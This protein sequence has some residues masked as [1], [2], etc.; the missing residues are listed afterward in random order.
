MRY[1]RI[2][3][4]DD[5]RRTLERFFLVFA[6]LMFILALT[7]DVRSSIF[8]EAMPSGNQGA[9]RNFTGGQLVDEDEEQNRGTE[10]E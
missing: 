4:E 1:E 8:S 10:L 5:K 7:T 9:Y 2:T 6:L 3:E